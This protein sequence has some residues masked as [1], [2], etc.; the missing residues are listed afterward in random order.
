LNWDEVAASSFHNFYF[1]EK[2]MIDV[3]NQKIVAITPPGAIVDNAG[4]TTAAIDTK[5]FAHLQIVVLFGAMDIA[6]AAL[7]AQ[8]SDDSGM[9]GAAD[10][11]GT[12][13]G[14][15]FTLPSAT[16][17]NTLLAININLKGNRKR[18]IDLVATGGDGAA[19]TYFT[20]FAVLSRAQEL[21]N[22]ATERGFT[23]EVFV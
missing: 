18:Y 11:T 22:S 7:K 3:N 19:G 17:D 20:A 8:E 1:E 12:V 10:I 14:T 21:P 16:A 5:G 23:T 9:S 15:A 4:F 2:E 6:M 13:G